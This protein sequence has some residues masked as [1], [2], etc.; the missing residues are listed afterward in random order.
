M[1]R[2]VRR[3]YVAL[4]VL[5]AALTA[6]GGP[7]EPERVHETVEAFGKASAAKDYQ[8]LC[9][10]LLAP[11]LVA[12]VEPP[13][14]PARS[15]C[16]RGSG[17]CRRRPSRS[18]GSASTGTTQPLR[19]TARRRAKSRRRTRCSW[20]AWRT[21]GG[22][23]HC[24]SERQPVSGM[25]R[26]ENRDTPNPSSASRASGLDLGN[27]PVAEVRRPHRAVADRDPDRVVAG[28]DPRRRPRPWSD[29]S[30]RPCRRPRSPPI[31]SPRR[32]RVRAGWRRRRS[33]R[34][35]PRAPRD[36]SA[37]RCRHSRPRPTR[38]PRPRRRRA[39]ARPRR[40]DRRAWPKPHRSASPCRPRSS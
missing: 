11:K 24:S 7:S 40:S 28:L 18:G 19:C 4:L 10:E 22:S 36:R 2:P 23:R 39:T 14:C 21:P 25:L 15:H 27:R 6:C 38:T 3:L 26:L 13:G 9:D 5:G 34:R 17:T 37:S 35:P 30:S 12:E 20:C 29:R 31:R 32:S 33:A 16:G 8:R 1:L